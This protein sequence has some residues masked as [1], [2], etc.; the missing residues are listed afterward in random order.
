MIL[1]IIIVNYNT[2]ALLKRC[3]N[4]LIQ[5]LINK[6][7]SKEFEIIV[8]DNGSTDNSLSLIAGEFPAVKLIANNH[9]LGFGIANNQGIKK[10]TGEYVLLINSDITVL[11]DSITQLLDY[12]TNSPE[13]DFAGGK[14]FNEDNTP[15]ASCGPFYNLVVSFVMLFL[16]GDK[17]G[18]TRYSPNMTREVDWVSGAC[19]IGK[20]EKFEK[21]GL[22]DEKIFM[23]MDEIDF[24][25][26]AKK[27]GF[28]VFYYPKAKFIH[29]GSGSAAGK[30][31]P[32]LNI[33]KGLLYF[34]SRYQ[35][36]LERRILIFM[37]KLK[38]LIA[39][40]IG[41]VTNNKY[42]K[43]TYAEAFKLV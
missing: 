36:P 39:L 16:R 17:L 31:Q 43:A 40:A 32:V 30:T 19:L 15:Q 27:M 5:S 8:I 20:K 7:D 13:V 14:L 1:S 2:S 21:V 11:D 24:L 4:S 12:I 26:R 25:Y 29:F 38:A 22:F 33:Y 23:Y 34:Y 28:H 9:N 18:I 6:I 37:L 10:A 42:L 3:I 41:I 35:S